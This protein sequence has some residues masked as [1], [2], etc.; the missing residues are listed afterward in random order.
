MNMWLK[1]YIFPGS[2][3]QFHLALSF[4]FLQTDICVCMKDVH[5]F[6]VHKLVINI[7]PF[8]WTCKNGQE[9]QME[10]VVYGK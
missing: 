1:P 8:T 4:S 3:P 5:V 6:T 9:Q 7:F 2:V 10:K